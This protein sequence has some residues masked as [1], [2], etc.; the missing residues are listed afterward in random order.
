MK[1]LTSAIMMATLMPIGTA[2]ALRPAIHLTSLVGM[3]LREP[4]TSRVSCLPRPTA[5]KI[6]RDGSAAVSDSYSQAPSAKRS[7][8]TAR[9][10]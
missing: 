2:S 10:A 8:D 7:P 5:T 4:G 1:M 3:P 6:C 9:G